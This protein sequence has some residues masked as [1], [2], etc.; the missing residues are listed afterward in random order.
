MIRVMNASP[1][2]IISVSEARKY[3]G[4]KGKILTDE[5]IEKMIRNFDDICKLHYRT[6]PK[7]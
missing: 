2:L 1:K 4:K 7:C 3:L 5:Q 6:I